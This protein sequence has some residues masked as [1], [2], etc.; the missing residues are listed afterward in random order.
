[1]KENWKNLT[2]HIWFP[3]LLFSLLVFLLTLWRQKF[4]ML[5]LTWK[6]IDFDA[7]E[8]WV[9]FSK[10]ERAYS[11]VAADT[12]WIGK[13]LRWS[14]KQRVLKLGSGFILTMMLC[15]LHLF[16]KFHSVLWDKYGLWIVIEK[17]NSFRRL[18]I[19]WYCLGRH[20]LQKFIQLMMIPFGISNYSMERAYWT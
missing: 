9:S 7:S 12:S 6:M 3:W 13:F 8:G 17:W 15:L 4:L 18:L 14:F 1:M 10:I 11:T 20:S 16:F 2:H 5:E 19:F